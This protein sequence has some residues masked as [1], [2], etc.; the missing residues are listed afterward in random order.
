MKHADKK[1]RPWKEA[2]QQVLTCG[3]FLAGLAIAIWY[4]GTRVPMAPL[5]EMLPHY[6]LQQS[7]R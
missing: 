4:I 1:R 7:Q 3:V 6:S 5:P 2:H